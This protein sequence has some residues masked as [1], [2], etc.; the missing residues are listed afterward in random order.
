M[1]YAKPTPADLKLRYAAFD[2]VSD[3][4]VQYWLTDAERFV[5]ESWTDADYAP[6]LMARAAHS[7]ALEGLGG[8]GA[9]DL[10]GLR[11]LGITDFKSG[12]FSASI[13]EDAVKASV[14]G[15]YGSTRYGQEFAALL[16]RNSGGPMLVGS[17]GCPC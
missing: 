17:L 10:A 11:D 6:A 13:A 14:A 16:K 8:N 1:P 2:A 3:E 12:S 7:M 5:D 4:R 9:S 15:G